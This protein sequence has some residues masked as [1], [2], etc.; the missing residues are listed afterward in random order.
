[1]IV[2]TPPRSA[3]RLLATAATCVA[4]LVLMPSWLSPG[5]AP[6]ADDEAKAQE[7]LERAE[8]K[9]EK[10]SYDQALSGYRKLVKAYPSTPAGAVALRR[11]QPNA[12]LGWSDLLR[13]GPSDNRVDVV[14]MGDG[15]MLSHLKSS[16]HSRSEDVLDAFEREPVLEE[17]L[18]YFNFIRAA[19]VSADDGIDGY[20]RESDTALDSYLTSR[21]TTGF[22]G[23]KTARVLEY[24]EQ[25]PAHDG[26]AFALIKNQSSAVPGGPVATVGGAQRD[27][28]AMVH[29]FGHAFAG[30]GDEFSNSGEHPFPHSRYPNVSTSETDV[31]WQHWLDEKQ[32]GVG[33]YDGASGR[34]DGAWRPTGSNCVMNG[35]KRFCIVCREAVVL[36]IYALV[37]GIE[38]EEP[39]AHD[40][41]APEEL[42]ATLKSNSDTQLAS[43]DFEVQTMQ[44][45][46]HDLVCTWWVVP[47][48]R[49]PKSS[50]VRMSHSD[51]AR[52]GKLEE[53]DGEPA[54]EQRVSKTGTYRFSVDPNEL[55]P[56]RYRVIC[57][58]TDTAQPRGEREPWVLLDAQ[59]L[60]TSERGWWIRVPE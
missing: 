35:S 28:D 2:S 38:S 34:L 23:V 30:L 26:I 44:P 48:H 10:G 32:A 14:I 53:I 11:T 22:G 25:L 49:A 8:K 20:G 29:A 31:P 7:L 39:A 19:V 40:L 1:M 4:V 15:Y 52:R 36:S 57:R 55:S 21:D 43:L 45:A 37:D 6:R 51:R 33:V 9:A 18:P 41:T 5:P 47:E 27:L 56:G 59:G 54:H 3:L 58:A 24:L 50:G 16:F 13:H 60:L 12:L 17:Y 42:V 46:S